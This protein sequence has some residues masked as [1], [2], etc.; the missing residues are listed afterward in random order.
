MAERQGRKISRSNAGRIIS[1][2][3]DVITFQDKSS[4]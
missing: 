2:A 4:G 1:A 3:D